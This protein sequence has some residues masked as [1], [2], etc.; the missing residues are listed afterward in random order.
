MSLR[1]ESHLFNRIVILTTDSIHTG[2]KPS[3]VG[4]TRL[5]CPPASW[6]PQELNQGREGRILRIGR[7]DPL[8]QASEP[9]NTS[10]KVCVPPAGS[11][12]LASARTDAALAPLTIRVIRVAKV[13]AALSKRIFTALAT[14]E[15]SRSVGAFTTLSTIYTSRPLSRLSVRRTVGCSRALS[16]I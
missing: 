5:T 14:V 7:A 16:H 6:L 15:W 11:T 9:L 13:A 4:S 3:F 1:S 8:W 2:G 10:L 12:C